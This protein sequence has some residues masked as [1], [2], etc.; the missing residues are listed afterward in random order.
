MYDCMIHMRDYILNCGLE[1]L[2]DVIYMRDMYCMANM[3]GCM[4]YMCDC[5]L[6][7]C[8]YMFHTHDCILD[9]FDGLSIICNFMFDMNNCVPARMVVYLTCAVVYA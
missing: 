8:H 9:M 6:D 3:Y 7:I 4:V 2:S 5:I 1:C